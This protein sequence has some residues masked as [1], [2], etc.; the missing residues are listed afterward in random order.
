M[1]RAARSRCHTPRHA[2]G[3]PKDRGLAATRD[4]Q[5]P[6]TVGTSARKPETMWWTGG[7]LQLPVQR[8]FC[9]VGT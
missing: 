5:R 2:V 7:V 8:V 6:V 9:S 1:P 3:I 4:E